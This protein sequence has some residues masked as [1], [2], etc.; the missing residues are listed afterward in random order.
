VVLLNVLAIVIFIIWIY[1]LTVTKRGKLDFWYFIIGSVGLFMFMLFV[2][3][4][5]VVQPLQR[6]VSVVAGMFGDMTGIYEAYY[7]KSIIF[8]TSKGSSIS[9]YVDFECSGV[10]EIMAFLSLV[11]FFPVYSAYEK[12]VVSIVGQFVIFLSNVLRIFVICFVIHIWGVDSYYIAHSIVGRIVFYACTVAL[13]FVVFTKAQLIRQK[14]GGI[15]YET[16]K[17]DIA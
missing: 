3:E 9:M 2:I 14:V 13:Y 1:M 5:V 6:A 11:W 4:P 10:V 16:D 15:R 17:S 8:I 7:N 12:I